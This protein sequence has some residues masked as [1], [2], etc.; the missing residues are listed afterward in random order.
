MEVNDMKEIIIADEDS[1]DDISPI[2][3]GEEACKSGHQFGPAVRDYY[4]IHFCIDGR[5]VFSDKYG[6]HEI[7]AGELFVIRPSELTVYRADDEDPWRYIWIAFTGKKAAKFDTGQSV[8]PYSEE[9]G[10]R[11]LYQRTAP[12]FPG[13][14]LLYRCGDP[15]LR[16]PWFG[17]RCGIDFFPSR[18]G[19]LQPQR[20]QQ[21]R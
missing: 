8:Y 21:A 19:Q 4:L 9:I 3:A 5:G 18:Q 7:E 1:F 14:P 12:I 20:R 2:F 16:Q 6:D 10:R 13:T 17:Y 15:L 11:P